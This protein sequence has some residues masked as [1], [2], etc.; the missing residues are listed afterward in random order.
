M[1]KLKYKF[2]SLVLA[3][4]LV[5]CSDYLDV[6]VDPDSP[7]TVDASL[8]MP[9]IMFYAAQTN[10]DHAEYGV[11]LS[12]CLTTGGNA[13][14]GALPYQSGWAFLSINRHPQW[15]RHFY[16]I[17]RNM[18]EMNLAAEEKGMYDYLA[19]GRT[20]MLMSTQL[21]T[22][23]FGDM[24]R[25]EAYLSSSPRYD[26]QESI[27]G[28]MLQE[29]NDLLEFYDSPEVNGVT[30]PLTIKQDRIFGGDARKWKQVVY[31]LK[32][33]ILLRNLPAMN[34][35]PEM[36]QQII[37]AA[38]S[39]LNGWTEPLYKYE[40]SSIAEQN[41]PWSIVAP[42]IN[43]WESR[44]NKLVTSIPSKFFMEQMLK[45]DPENDVEQNIEDFRNEYHPD[46]R[47]AYLMEKRLGRTAPAKYAYRYLENNYGKPASLENVEYPDLH[48]SVL[49][50]KASA[51]SLIST[52]E[53][54][55]IIAEA[56]YWKNE[57][58][59]A[60]EALKNGVSA[61]MKKL[62]IPQERIN[63]YLNSDLVPGVSNLTLSDIMREKYIAMYLQPEQWNDMRRYNYSNNEQNKFGLLGEEVII[64]PTLRR[65]Y[66]LYVSYWD[67]S[68]PNEWI[69]RINYDPETEQIY[70]VSE[71]IRLGA[72]D[73]ATK[74]GTPE[75]LKK[76]MIW[77]PAYNK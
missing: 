47:I 1:N 24:P 70:S 26:S 25:T 3:I 44:D 67:I 54:Y 48:T 28:W 66:N 63:E 22:D 64:Y 56:S 77:S 33:R 38:E 2:L 23:A 73:P 68:N 58:P 74:S 36:C 49:T 59:K 50:E 14:N 20:I 30:R 15:R 40:D 21:T 43:T 57:K 52:E 17:G 16:D 60:V 12:Q 69:Q 31:A 41:C 34:T 5:G 19:V 7:A 37:S 46:P 4:S 76:P 53:L 13:Q 55:L 75:W 35:S 9:A 45:Y 51:I 8:I 32:A 27:Y 42:K 18:V 29:A 11:Y 10:Y 65:P 39:A 62:G 6:N 61:H 72:Y 71:L